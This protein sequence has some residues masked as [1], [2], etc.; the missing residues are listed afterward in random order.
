MPENAGNI[1][2]QELG[3]ERDDDPRCEKRKVEVGE[4]WNVTTSYLEL[5]KNSTIKYCTPSCSHNMVWENTS[6]VG[7]SIKDF[8][9][10]YLN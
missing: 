2:C 9:D 7:D 5:S 4:Q 10:K 1:T 8:I 3:Y 6:W